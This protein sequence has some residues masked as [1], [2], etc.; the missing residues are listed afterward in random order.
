MKQTNF[1]QKMNK[2]TQHIIK[3]R[4]VGSRCLIVIFLFLFSFPMNGQNYEWAKKM[5]GTESYGRGMVADKDG[6]IYVVGEIRDTVD[7]DPGPGI[8]LLYPL[9]SSGGRGGFLAKYDANG[10]Y[11]WAQR[12]IGGG[13]ATAD[14]LALDTFGNIYVTGTFSGTYDVQTSSGTVELSTVV[15][16]YTWGSDAFSTDMF[17]MKFNSAGV[18]MWAGHMPA[19]PI[20]PMMTHGTSNGFS[21]AVDRTGNVYVTGIFTR[22]VDFNPGPGYDTLSA[23]SGTAIGN[24]SNLFVA[25]YDTDGNYV[26]AGNVG[27]SHYVQGKDIVVDTTGN[28]DKLY[29][30]GFLVGMADFDLGS[31]VANLGYDAPRV[32]AFLA[33]Y[34]T[35][36]MYLWANAILADSNS[37][38]GPATGASL[39]VDTFGNI[40]LTGFIT[41]KY[42]FDPSI[43]TAMF[44]GLGTCMY[45][46]KYDSSGNYLW[47]QNVEQAPGNLSEP[48]SLALDV[49][50]NAYITGFF[51]YFT[52]TVID[53]DPSP[54]T[55][56]LQ[57]MGVLDMFVAKYGTCGSLLSA[58]SMATTGGSRAE[59]MV[60]MPNGDAYFT[61]YF[62]GSIDFD[63]GP[64]TATLSAS[65]PTAFLSKLQFDVDSIPTT[66]ITEVACGDSFTLNNQT[67]NASGTYRQLLPGTVQCDSLVVFNLTLSQV[68]EPIIT[69]DEF[70]LGLTQTYATYQW[71]KDG[72][73]LSGAITPTYHVTEN[74][75]YQVAVTN[76]EGCTDTSA[77]Y[78]VDNVS[79]S[80]VSGLGQ[81][82]KVYPNPTSNQLTISSPTKVNA[83][84]FSIDGRQVLHVENARSISLNGLLSGLYILQLSDTE[85][86]VIKYEK[87]VKQ[88]Q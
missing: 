65:D 88:P 86:H 85:G 59:A 36:G 20:D 47:A 14:A 21:C 82:I 81:Q 13:I 15:G 58:V 62:N 6:S 8:A 25:K 22:T 69:V 54:D 70:V 72:I 64:G 19:V 34:D 16:T 38:T 33:K 60:I 28:E 79:T 74:G 46:A 5:E 63:P 11:L 31:S 53:F 75:D 49:T 57:T 29:L 26:W 17:L 7:F 45:L 41:G 77:I 39:A 30:T 44:T 50:G 2:P 48:R 83:I 71:I 35:S 24:H 66:V 80:D 10:N 55:T 18:C 73:E 87:I 42:D 51:G 67:Y 27:G 61:G 32:H 78:V 40:L 3:I 56:L 43:D 4:W 37:T 9:Y 23:V 12:I 84:L 1:Y 76:D 68:A 52:G